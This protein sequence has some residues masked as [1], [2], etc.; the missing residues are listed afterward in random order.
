MTRNFSQVYNANLV[1]SH[2]RMHKIRA[3]TNLFG[4]K[5]KNIFNGAKDI[6]ILINSLFIIILNETIHSNLLPDNSL[7]NQTTFS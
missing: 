7:D 4:Q 5:A 1:T 2:Q 6:V 3:M